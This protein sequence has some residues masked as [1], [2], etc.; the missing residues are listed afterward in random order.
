MT[1]GK[2]VFLVDDDRLVLKAITRELKR[3]RKELFHGGELAIHEFPSA[4]EAL[5]NIES[6]KPD[7]I[8]SDNTMP[9]ILGIEFLKMVRQD[10]PHIRTIM[11]TGGPVEGPI[12]EAADGGLMDRLFVKPWDGKELVACVRELLR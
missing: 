6:L 8:I 5:E 9:G 3:N 4:V 2:V 1:R 11:L 12:Q 7:L 10:K